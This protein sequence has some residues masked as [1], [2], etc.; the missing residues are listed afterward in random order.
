[1]T[2]TNAIGWVKDSSF[3]EPIF[4]SCVVQRHC[5]NYRDYVGGWKYLTF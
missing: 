5:I 2:R 1:M 3:Q 4:I